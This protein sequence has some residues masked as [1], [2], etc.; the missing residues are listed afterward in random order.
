M[1]ELVGSS[2]IFSGNYV[3]RSQLIKRDREKNA[4]VEGKRIYYESEKKYWMKGS[5]H[6]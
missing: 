5:K 6:G 4:G 1:Y 3:I 2:W